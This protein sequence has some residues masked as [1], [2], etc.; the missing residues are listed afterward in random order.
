MNPG[1]VETP[2]VMIAMPIKSVIHQVQTAIAVC[3]RAGVESQYFS[4][5]FSLSVARP[6]NVS[7][8]AKPMVC[9][10]VVEDDSRL[11]VKRLI[12]VVGAVV[13][14]ILLSP[15]MLLVAIALTLTQ[16]WTRFVQ[17]RALWLEQAALQKMYKFRT[18]VS[19]AESLQGSLEAQNEK[20][21][22][23]FKIKN[24][25]ADHAP[26]PFPSDQLDR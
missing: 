13:G 2:D 22:P 15:L 21:G 26:R 8:D 18:M 19:N 9:L 1:V 20:S 14:I 12:D 11:A 25:P 5:I 17:P 6:Q 10:K 24:D 16:R 3:E 4:Q 23:I 7:H